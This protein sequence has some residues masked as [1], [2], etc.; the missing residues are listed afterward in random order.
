MPARRQ[1]R[2]HPLAGPRRLRGASPTSTLLRR[3]GG[4]ERANV[5]ESK[6][7]IETYHVDWSPDGKYVAFSY[8]P[9]T[10]GKSLK[11]LLPEFPGVEAPGWN[12]T[13]ADV[14]KKNAYV[15]ITMDGKSWKEPDWM[16]VK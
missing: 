1:P 2:R 3:S 14:S 16:F 9:K 13:I 15:Q 12:C 7:P 6:D 10:K 11:G 8:G 4:E 5:V